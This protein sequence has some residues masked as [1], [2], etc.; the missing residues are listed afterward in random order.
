MLEKFGP[1]KTLFCIFLSDCKNNAINSESFMISMGILYAAA[2]PLFYILNLYY[3]APQRHS[4][5]NFRIV[6]V[7]LSLA[8]IFKNYWPY[9]LRCFL[10]LVWYITIVLAMPCFTTFML[11]KNNL[12]SAWALNTIVIAIIMMLIVDWILYSIL[13]I[14]G[15]LLGL[16]LYIL[17]TQSPFSFTIDHTPITILDIVCAYIYSL[18][19]GII[20][21]RTKG[22]IEQ[23]KLEGMKIVG[24][25]VA[26]EL[27][28]PLASID[29]AI[30]GAK[31][32]LP[33]LIHAYELAK[34]HNLPVPYIR[35]DHY[36]TLFRILESIEMEVKA[37]HNIIDMLLIKINSKIIFREDNL[38]VCS[39]TNCVNE[40]INRYP[41]T[42]PVHKSL[43]LVDIK[44]DFLFNGKN[45]FVVHIIFNLLKNALYFIQSAKKGEIFIWTAL[46]KKSNTLYFKDTSKGMNP[47]VYD[48]LFRKYFVSDTHNGTGLGL[49]F[50]K[51]VMDSIDGSI[52]CKTQLNEYTQFAL[53]FPVIDPL[54]NLPQQTVN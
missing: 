48:T 9:K 50:C 47:K 41:F 38:D 30:T 37:S 28:T 44:D 13:L 5:I 31:R 1:I 21:N 15:I 4:E 6:V 23:A 11:F 8:L 26:H 32:Y 46:G 7:F 12:S 18:L 34:N 49:A 14:L 24:S 53:N 36:H 54:V 39:I 40:A 45:L 17:T 33:K 52:E 3:L 2:Q 20:F 16:C 27:R 10:P 25:N 22:L 35:Q 51:M 42:D 43:V 29:G 19:M